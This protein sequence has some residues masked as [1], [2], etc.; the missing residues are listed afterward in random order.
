MNWYPSTALEMFRPPMWTTFSRP[1]E[2]FGVK[3]LVESD[4]G[5]YEPPSPLSHKVKVNLG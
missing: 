4:P 1:F 2:S 3:L 5:H